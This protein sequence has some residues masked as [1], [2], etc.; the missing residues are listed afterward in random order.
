MD[1]WETMTRNHFTHEAQMAGFVRGMTCAALLALGLGAAGPG[2]AQADFL[3]PG[4]GFISV[5]AAGIET[6]ELDDWLAARDY[7][8]FGQSAV[9]VGLGAYR[10][11]SS[12]V[13]LGGEFN[14]LIVGD[15]AH[16]GRRVGLGGGYATLGAGYVVNLSPRARVYPRL[17]LGVGG[18]GLWATREDTV[19]FEEVLAGRTDDPDR[20]PVLSRDGPV[21]DLGA[22]AEFLPGGRRGPLIGVRAGYLAGPF[23]SHW[24]AYEDTATGGPD[25]SITGPY[26]RL[27]VGWAWRR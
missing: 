14:G 20:E 6:G 18:M 8:T 5:G 27:T 2:A 3:G 19:D 16:G 26:V 13:M 9:T 4:G 11:L 25:A 1:V 24:D 15:E 17:G 22:G 23:T 12:G 10:I 7:P 21:I